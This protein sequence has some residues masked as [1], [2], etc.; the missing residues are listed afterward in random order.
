MKDAFRLVVRE[1]G[2]GTPSRSFN[3]RL[4]IVIMADIL[5]GAAL[6][7]LFAMWHHGYVM[8]GGKGL[9]VSPRSGA[10]YT[11]T[12][13]FKTADNGGAEG[14]FD[15]SG[16]FEKETPETAY[17]GNTLYYS[18]SGAEIS[19]TDY[20]LKSGAVKVADVYIADISRLKAPRAN[21]FYGKGQREDPALL[22]ERHQALFSITGDNYS[23][24]WGGVIMRDGVLYSKDVTSDVCVLYW[25]GEMKTF[26]RNDFDLAQTVLDGAYQIWSCGPVL[27]ESGDVTREAQQDDSIPMRRAAIGYYEPGHYCFVIMEGNVSAND[28]ALNMQALGCE[29]AY[30]LAGGSYAE[31]NFDGQVISQLQEADRECADIIMITR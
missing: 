16:R 12:D 2:E 20:N 3:T 9:M 21:D 15:F 17:E 19:I 14:Y 30:E 24:R 8:Y 18:D 11:M 28:I 27:L 29:S 10:A 5:L 1:E 25:N 13:D 7:S 26:G 4:F 6:L 22:S 23:Q 31:M